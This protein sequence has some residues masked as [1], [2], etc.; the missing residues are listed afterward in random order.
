VGLEYAVYMVC[1]A[2]ICGL[3]GM[4]GWNMRFIWSVGLEYAVY[5]VCRSGIY[6][7]YGV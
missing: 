1:R 2:G 3:Y 6:G 4:K 7:L 5:M